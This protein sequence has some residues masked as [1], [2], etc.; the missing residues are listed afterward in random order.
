MIDLITVVFRPEIPYLEIQ[1]KSIENNFSEDQIK[2]IYIVVNDHDSVANLIDKN[3]YGKYADRVVVYPYSVFGYVNRVGGWDNQQLCKLLAAARSTC[4]WSVVI[5]AKT[6]FV[7]TFKTELFFDLDNK[8]CTTKLLPQPVFES[9][10]DCVE[11]LYNITLDHIIGPGGVPF[12]F[13]TKTVNLLIEDTEKLT[14]KSFIEFFLDNV[15]Y[16]NLITE[17]YL[18]SAYVKYKYGSFNELYV[19]KQK[20]N[21]VNIAEWEADNFQELFLSMQ[22]FLTLTVSIASK[23]WVLLSDEN[24]IAYLQFLYKKNLIT[25]VQNTLKKLNTV[26]N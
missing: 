17:F 13:H 3:W 15:C 4:E 7:K 18:Y 14:N 20:W 6:F 5:D 26:I 19:D 12:L 8:A 21:C 1:A 24:K 9:A 23:T 10:K 22:K 2:N 16:P 11:K 25:D